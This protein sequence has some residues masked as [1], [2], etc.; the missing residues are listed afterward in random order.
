M[1]LTGVSLFFSTDV[2]INH[3]KSHNVYYI[4][5]GLVL[6]VVVGLNS[7]EKLIIL[8][9]C[10]GIPG[11]VGPRGDQGTAGNTGQRGPPGIPGKA[12][13]SGRKGKVTKGR[14]LCFPIR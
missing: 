6:P 7:T 13:K 10:P 8:Q 5:R 2:P 1:E 9:G 3:F 4:E 12:G 11:A 14:E